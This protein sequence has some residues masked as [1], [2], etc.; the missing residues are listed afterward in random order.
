MPLRVVRTIRDER[1]WFGT[2]L[3]HRD[4]GKFEAF[5]RMNS[6]D[7]NKISRFQRKATLG[8]LSRF[9]YAHARPDCGLSGTRPLSCARYR[10]QDGMP[11]RHLPHAQALRR[12]RP[13]AGV[14]Q[15]EVEENAF[16][17]FRE[18]LEPRTGCRL[19]QRSYRSAETRRK[20]CFVFSS[21]AHRHTG[22]ERTAAGD[23]AQLDQGLSKGR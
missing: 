5:A 20:R 19:F 11:Y 12:L 4:N 21:G 23:A 7:A 9:Q 13:R 6:H 17:N 18:G 10:E 8:P 3:C 14:S 22:I 2:Q 16:H 15:P 1:A